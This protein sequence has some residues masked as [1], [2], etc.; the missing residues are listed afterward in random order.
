MHSMGEKKREETGKRKMFSPC[1]SL[2]MLPEVGKSRK[3]INHT[4]YFLTVNT[5]FYSRAAGERAL[6]N[7]EILAS[8]APHLSKEEEQMI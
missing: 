6:C 5:Q 2:V 8:L 7:F 4:Q 3:I 1:V